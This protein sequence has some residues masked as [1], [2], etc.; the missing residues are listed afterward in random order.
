MKKTMPRLDRR[1]VMCECDIS[2]Q[3]VQAAFCFDCR[4]KRNAQRAKDRINALKQIQRELAKEL[5]A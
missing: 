5:T 4:A 1:C 2:A 3:H